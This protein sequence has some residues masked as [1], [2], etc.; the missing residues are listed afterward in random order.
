[1]I[2]QRLL[3][4]ASVSAFICVLSA[5]VTD[6]DPDTVPFVGPGDHLPYFAVRLADGSAVTTADLAGAPSVI[7]F[8]NT[9]CPDCRRELPVVDRAFRSHSAS[10]RFI[11]VAREETASSIADFWREEGLALPYAPQ[12]DRKIYSLFVREGIPRIFISDV[13]LTVRA[14]F[15]PDDRLSDGMLNDVLNS[16]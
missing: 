14:V 8:F 15:G 2:I 6:A 11:A 9:S 16:L 3:R 7:V 13:S 5:C 4:V 1:M 12:R 10:V